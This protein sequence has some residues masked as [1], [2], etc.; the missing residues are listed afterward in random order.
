MILLGNSWTET[1]LLSLRT[2]GRRCSL[3]PG[4]EQTESSSGGEPSQR[5][6]RVLCDSAH[7]KPQTARLPPEA[8]GPGGPP[9]EQM[10][11]RAGRTW[12][13]SGD[14]LQTAPP[15][16]IWKTAAGGRLPIPGLRQNH[17]NSV[18]QSDLV[19]GWRLPRSTCQPQD[20]GGRLP[21]PASVCFPHTPE[22]GSNLSGNVKA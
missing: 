13:P 2:P 4:E 8:P 19:S 1:H 3:R 5:G 11:K 17:V 12:L 16:L 15:S 22:A 14:F 18:R 9:H 10:S 20:E 21:P 7:L 6:S